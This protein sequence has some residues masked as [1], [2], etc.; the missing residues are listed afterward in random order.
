MSRVNTRDLHLGTS[1]YLLQ[2]NQEKRQTPENSP[3][4]AQASS[5]SSFQAKGGF[6]SPMLHTNKPKQELK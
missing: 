4:V 6:L 5:Y 2:E 3:F 1:T